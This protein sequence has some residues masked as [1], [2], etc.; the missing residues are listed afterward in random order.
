MDY[1]R[2]AHAID[3]PTIGGKK[4]TVVGAGGGADFI[5]NAVRSGI[6]SVDVVDPDRVGPENLCRQGHFTDEVGDYKVFAVEK[7]LRRID[8]AVR[9]RPWEVDF[10]AFTDAEIDRCFGDTDVFVFATD[11]HRAQARGNEVCLRL[12]RPGVWIG[13]YP[14]GRAGEVFFWKP[15]LPSCYRCALSARYAAQETRPHDPPSDGADVAAVALVDSL[16]LMITLGLL[17]EGADNR[18]GRLIGQLGGRQF[19]Q[20]K[21]DPGWGWNGRDLFRDLLQIPDGND[22]YAGFVTVARRDPDPGGRCPDCLQFRRKD[23]TAIPP[24]PSKV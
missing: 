19:L 4:L 23:P 17:T 22:V 21:I 5:R 6:R 16:A 2:I 18:Y 14:G 20:V 24:E 8:P 3:I 1:Q 9:V 12:N 7:S 11:S 13:V 15:G 10:R